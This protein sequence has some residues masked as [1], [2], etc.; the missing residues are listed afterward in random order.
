MTRLERELGQ[1]PDSAAAAYWM[2]AAAR[3]AGDPARAWNLAMAGWVRAGRGAVTLR[4][5][6]DR[7][8]LQGCDPGSGD[9]PQ[10]RLA[11]FPR[12]DRGDGGLGRPLGCDEG[13]VGVALTG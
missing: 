8:V 12:C 6:L 9:F 1:H 3:G 7:L 11:R 2:V 10:Q 4:A 13:A 5:D